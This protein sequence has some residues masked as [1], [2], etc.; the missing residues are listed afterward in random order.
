V[1]R[2]SLSDGIRPRRV[3]HRRGIDVSLE[4]FPELSHLGFDIF[5]HVGGL[6]KHEHPGQ[7]EICLIMRGHVTWWA[8]EK[9]YDL[10]GGDVYFTWPDEPHGGLHELMHPCTI[11]WTTVSIPKPGS[12]GVRGFL[13]LPRAEAQEL[14]AGVYKLP[15]RH[16]RGAAKLEPYFQA[17]FEALE[18]R[19]MLGVT[20][21]RA[22]LQGML[23]T[24]VTLPL[25]NAPNSS[26][27]GFVPP[28][29]ARAREFLDSCPSPWPAVAELAD[30]SGMSGSHFHACFLREVGAAPM[31]Y[32]HR[33]RLS[34][35]KELLAQP[36][37][38]VSRVAERLGYYSSQHLAACFRRYLGQ[39][40]SEAAGRRVGKAA[41][42]ESGK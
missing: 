40:P 31:E 14:S 22:A 38:T 15:D 11:Y 16:L 28:G 12:P 19:T 42:I 3:K 8:R 27:T 5:T 36:H 6:G 18:T 20:R 32:S 37:A 34:R 35:A 17:I 13:S 39:T 4:A 23:A 26:G 30:L 10:R 21:A 9:L 7:F 25:A 29:I 2:Q 24:W 33:A 41:S 1:A